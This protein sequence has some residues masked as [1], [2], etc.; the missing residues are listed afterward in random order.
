MWGLS[1]KGCVVKKPGDN[2]TLSAEDGEALIA[3]VHLSN[4]PRAD[5]ERVEGVIR[6]YFYVVFALQEAKLSA[7][8]LRSL[9]FGKRPEPSR[10]RRKHRPL[11]AKRIAMGQMPLPCSKPMPTEQARRGIK[12]RRGNRRGRSGPSPQAGTVQGRAA[13][14]PLPMQVPRASSAA[15]R[16]W[17]WVSAARCVVRATSMRCPPGWRFASTAMPCSVPCATSEKSCAARRAVQS[18]RPSCL[19]A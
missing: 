16:S 13:W 6:M 19:L 5:A 1:R 10:P 15:T 12:R 4:L 3:R 14:V 7:K 9:L 18:L 2:L 17:R 8:R 11:P